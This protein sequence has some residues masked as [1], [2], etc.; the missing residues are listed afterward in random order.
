MDE[1]PTST[2]RGRGI[3]ADLWAQICAQKPGMA[4]KAEFE[5]SD[6]AD[7]IRYQLRQ[8][9]KSEKKF[10]S[11]SRFADGKTRYFWLEKAQP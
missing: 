1:V 6:H 5:S 7:Y 10:L 2:A 11:S 3:A 9:A 8:K 4:V